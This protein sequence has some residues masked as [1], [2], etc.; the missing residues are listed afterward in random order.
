[1][2]R[3]FSRKKD[4][5][6]V[7]RNNAIEE[8][9]DDRQIYISARLWHEIQPKIDLQPFIFALHEGIDL[10]R[11]GNGL[12][13]FYFTF[14]I[15]LPDK[16]LWPPGTYFSRKREAAEIAVDIDYDRI[17]QATKAEAFE[18]MERAY[19]EGIDLIKTLPLKSSFDVEA[20]RKDVAAIFT[21]ERWYEEFS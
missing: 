18:L 15:L 12:K 20:F 10:T 5:M 21:K 16:S 4:G 8:F 9:P 14:L 3:P 1:M 17:K 13:K 6:K 2:Y 11:Y 19:L 7:L